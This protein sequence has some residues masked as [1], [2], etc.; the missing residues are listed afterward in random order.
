MADGW[1]LVQSR[2][3]RRKTKRRQAPEANSRVQIGNSFN[4]VGKSN[5]KNAEKNLTHDLQTLNKFYTTGRQIFNES[6]ASD[7]LLALPKIYDSFP[8]DALIENARAYRL[9]TSTEKLWDFLRQKIKLP[10]LIEFFVYL[11]HYVSNRVAA[12]VDAFRFDDSWSFSCIIINNCFSFPIL[13]W[14]V[15]SGAISC[16]QTEKQE[17]ERYQKWS[18]EI[19]A[20]IHEED[21]AFFDTVFDQGWDPG[22]W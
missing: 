4:P 8:L 10:I 9:S 12:M 2:K 6:I 3:S 19:L 20:Q 15:M 18:L 5:F 17:F 14:A 1:T 21:D 16:L 22:E 11:A 13:R 7:P